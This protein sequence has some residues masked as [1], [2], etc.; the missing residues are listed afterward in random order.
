[1]TES[2]KHVQPLYWSILSSVEGALPRVCKWEIK[3]AF[4]KDKQWI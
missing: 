4:L 1:M 2:G 3:P